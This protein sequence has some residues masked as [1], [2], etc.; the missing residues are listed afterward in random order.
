MSAVIF[1]FDGTIA[2]SFD[3]VV[4]VFHHLTNREDVLTT[5]DVAKLRGYPLSV[6]ADRLGVPLWKVPFLLFRGRH[7]MTKYIPRLH[8][9]EGMGKVI[10]ELHAEGH[11][12]FIMSSNSTRNVKKFLKQHHMYKYFT[13]V[14]GGAGL[15]N[16]SKALGKLVRQN[17]LDLKDCIYI[18][19]ETRDVDAAHEVGMRVIAVTWGFAEASFLAELK[20]T[21]IAH[22]R[23]DIVRILEEL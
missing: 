19:D 4:D 6:V 8:M 3:A 21:A 12:L 14:R 20:P 23:Q 1:D 7:M 9:F 16:K 10:E 18:G 11:D 17:S 5:D 22:E 2:D 13:E 15:L